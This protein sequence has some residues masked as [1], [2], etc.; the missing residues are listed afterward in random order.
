MHIPAAIGLVL[1]VEVF[2]VAAVSS[3][4]L[5]ALDLLLP[6][7]AALDLL[8]VADPFLCFEPASAHA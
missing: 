8:E 6:P 5:L 4:S 3:S 2:V 7:L 1:I